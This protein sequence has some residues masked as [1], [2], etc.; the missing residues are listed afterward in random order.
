MCNFVIVELDTG[1][2]QFFERLSD[3][4][5]YAKTQESRRHHSVEFV[6]LFSEDDVLGIYQGQ[7]LRWLLRS[8]DNV[9]QW[10]KSVC[11][12]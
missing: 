10:V 2:R 12:D 3:G 9:K 11:Q 7:E 1:D 8:V 4:F 5:R 6:G